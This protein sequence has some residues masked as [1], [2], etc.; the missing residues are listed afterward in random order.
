MAGLGPMTGIPIGNIGPQSGANYS[1]YLEMWR[2]K[3]SQNQTAQQL[4]LQQQAAE[5]Q[6]REFEQRMAEERRQF[7]TSTK[8]R[9]D[10]FM[11]SSDLERQ[12]L[13]LR[14]ELGRGELGLRGEEVRGGLGIR[15]QQLGLQERELAGNEQSRERQFGLE[16][17]RIAGAERSQAFDETKFYESLGM[18]KDKLDWQK[19]I[20]VQNQARAQYL[21]E[22][23][24][25]RVAIQES[26]AAGEADERTAKVELLK[27]EAEKAT[28]VLKELKEQGAF[29]GLSAEQADVAAD[30]I[31]RGEKLPAI[32]AAIVSRDPKAAKAV[33]ALY[34]LARNAKALE[35]ADIE[36]EAARAR[37]DLTRSQTASQEMENKLVAS[38]MPTVTESAGTPEAQKVAA[39]AKAR[40]AASAERARKAAEGSLGEVG[41]VRSSLDEKLAEIEGDTSEEANARRA[42]LKR[43][44]ELLAEYGD[45]D[46]LPG[47]L[48]IRWEDAAGLVGLGLRGVRTAN[49]LRQEFGIGEEGELRD[50]LDKYDIEP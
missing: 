28:E 21:A 9:G 36:A 24:G 13:N 19:D 41:E 15:Q 29:E 37:T 46:D 17:R 33:E 20:E 1:P 39:D 32:I 45:D 18:E 12:G 31:Y 16:E 26:V 25:R 30:Y 43:I 7:D 44:E 35:G 34:T 5:Q 11:T 50:L 14:A 27:L 42:S 47:S 48:R 3:Q 22:L 49:R 4:A 40:E 10:Q 2:L 38:K 23:D 8:Q 6:R